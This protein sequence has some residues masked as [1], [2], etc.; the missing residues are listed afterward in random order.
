MY[1]ARHYKCINVTQSR[2]VTGGGI[3]GSGEGYGK[4][5]SE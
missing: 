2:K 1:K 5:G 3:D 4:T